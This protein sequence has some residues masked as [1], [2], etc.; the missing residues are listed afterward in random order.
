MSM[1]RNFHS[2]RS[3]NT[4]EFNKNKNQHYNSVLMKTESK[5]GRFNSYTL[6]KDGDPVC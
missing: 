4:L 1:L 2:I 5:L 3:I 6:F